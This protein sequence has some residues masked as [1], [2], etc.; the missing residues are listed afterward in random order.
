MNNDKSTSD[1]VDATRA[2][3]EVEVVVQ[4]F[5]TSL[6]RN[7]RGLELH[8]PPALLPVEIATGAH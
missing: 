5:L 1:N 8:A 2:Y 3:V 7:R 4:S 6:L